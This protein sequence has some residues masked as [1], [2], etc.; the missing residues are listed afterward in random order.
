MKIRFSYILLMLLATGCITNHKEEYDPEMK[1]LFHPVM[2][3]QTKTQYSIEHYPEGQ[4]FAVNVWTLEKEQCWR[5]NA[6]DADIYISGEYAYMSDADR[7]ALMDDHLW[8]EREKKVTVIGYSPVRSF[9]SCTSFHGASCT[10]DMRESQEDLLYTDPQT[11]LDKVEC[12]GTV[13]MPFYHALS[14]VDFEVKNRVRDDE[15]IFIKSIWIDG[16][17]CCGTFNSLPVPTWELEEDEMELLFFEGHQP[18]SNNPIEIGTAW[19]IIPQVLSTKVTVEY[20]YRT[21]ANTGFTLM[22]KTCDLQTN[23]K[24]GRHYTYTL[25]VGIDEV[26][27]LLEIIEDKFKSQAVPEEQTD[28]EETEETAE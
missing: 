5:H 19:N 7:W 15:E 20:E 1:L 11:D 6:E 2:Q 4:P 28:T 18:T 13:I 16:V 27:F 22:L 25:A 21:A 12:G 3:V 23:L 24:P 9:G 10:Y 17:R 14:Q 8:P 26:Q